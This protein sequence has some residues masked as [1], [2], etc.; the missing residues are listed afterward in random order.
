LTNRLVR[1]HDE[2]SLGRGT[3]LSR[4]H[5]RDGSQPDPT[6]FRCSKPIRPGAVVRFSQDGWTHLTCEPRDGSI[7]RVEALEE[8]FVTTDTSGCL[9]L[10][11]S[12]CEAVTGYRRTDVLGQSLLTLLVPEAWQA[13]MAERLHHA[14]NESLEQPFRCPWRTRSGEERMIEWRCGVRARG[15]PD[16]VVFAIG[17][18]IE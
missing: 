2:Q 9:V 17:R 11:N 12:A 18:V 5:T 1:H 14:S 6:C 3:T 10:F 16:Q 7:R 15:T 8:L 13:A 4:G